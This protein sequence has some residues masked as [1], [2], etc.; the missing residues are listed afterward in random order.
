MVCVRVCGVCVCV[1]CVMCVC[2]YG[3]SV[4]VWCVYFCVCMCVCVVCVCMACDVCVTEMCS[5]KLDK[6]SMTLKYTTPNLCSS[7]RVMY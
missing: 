2:V 5:N 7:F 1:W 6:H 3:L 4:C